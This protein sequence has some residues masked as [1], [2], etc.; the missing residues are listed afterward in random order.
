MWAPDPSPTL[1]DDP[2]EPTP[3][4][5][6]AVTSHA[7]S[8]FNEAAKLCTYYSPHLTETETDS[9]ISSHYP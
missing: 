3:Q 8:C 4:Q 9:Q 2:L 7:I 5:A 1:L 6:P